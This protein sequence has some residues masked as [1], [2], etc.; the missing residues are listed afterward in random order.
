[1]EG[2]G[3]IQELNTGHNGFIDIMLGTGLTGL[4][5]VVLLFVLVAWLLLKLDSR[6][7]LAHY[8]F[9]AFLISNVTESYLFYFQ[10]IMWTMFVLLIA[11][12]YVNGRSKRMRRRY[13]RTQPV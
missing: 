7:F 9:I 2:L 10:N 8:I 13:K 6:F 4:T 11:V 12:A 1:M 3:F 5:V